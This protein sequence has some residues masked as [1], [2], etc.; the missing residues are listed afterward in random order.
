MDQHPPVP[1]VPKALKKEF[2]RRLQEMASARGMN[3]SD[4]ARK[5][6]Q[7]M[8]EG[9]SIGRDTISHSIRG[10]S[11]PRPDRHLAI[12]KALDCTTEDLPLP[13]PAKMEDVRRR[14]TDSMEVLS[15]ADG[16]VNIRLNRTVSM[17]TASKIMTLLSREPAAPSAGG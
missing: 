17:E 11:M 15:L 8:P 13:K 2:G 3:Q 16:R 14:R 10:V 1:R 12:C 4:L 5:A 6:S 7:H 9:R